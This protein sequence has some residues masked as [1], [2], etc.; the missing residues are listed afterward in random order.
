MAKG[1]PKAQAIKKA[2][3][4]LPGT[5]NIPEHQVQNGVASL[6]QKE[7]LSKAG[8]GFMPNAGVSAKG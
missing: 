8:T 1:L 2:K 3:A 7:Q 6:Q 5:E 4:E